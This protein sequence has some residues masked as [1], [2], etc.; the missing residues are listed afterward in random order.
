G[1][2]ERMIDLEAATELAQEAG[3]LH[4][5]AEDPGIAARRRRRAIDTEV[6]PGRGGRDT[7]HAH[8][9]RAP[10]DTG[11]PARGVDPSV[12]TL[13]HDTVAAAVRVVPP[14]PIAVAVADPDAA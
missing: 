14:D 1:G 8:V 10:V 6:E 7:P 12:A 5:A 4:R 3:H 2:L 11:V 9:P 13:T